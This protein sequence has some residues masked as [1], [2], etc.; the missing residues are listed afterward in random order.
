[1]M[2]QEEEQQ[3]IYALNQVVGFFNKELDELQTDLWMRALRKHPYHLVKRGLADYTEIGKFAPK[4]K[5][6]L[7]LVDS[8]KEQTRRDTPLPAPEP[9]GE[10]ASAKEA[11]AW[12]YV[13]SQWGGDGST[14]FSAPN[15]DADEI[16]EAVLMVNRFVRESGNWDAIPPHLWLF[17]VH[18]HEYPG[19]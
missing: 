15:M 7:E 12:R 13:I 17:E 2:T 1:M 5:D 8:Y 18:G 10:V 6:I 19:A 14:M 11:R 3:C 4:P 16:E 9:T